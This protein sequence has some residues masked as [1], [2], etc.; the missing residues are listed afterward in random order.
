M[1]QHPK[2]MVLTVCVLFIIGAGYYLYQHGKILALSA[3]PSDNQYQLIVE[4]K[5]VNLEYNN[6]V[7]NS[8]NVA[9]S[10][11]ETLIKKGD[12]VEVDVAPYDRIVLTSSAEEFDSVP[13]RGKSKIEVMVKDLDFTKDNLQKID[14]VVRENRGRYA[15]STAKW[16]FYFTIERKVEFSDIV[17]NAFKSGSNKRVT[18]MQ[19]PTPLSSPPILVVSPKPSPTITSV[20][21]QTPIVSTSPTP[22]TKLV[23]ATPRNTTIDSINKTFTLGSSKEEVEAIMG[24]PDSNIFDSWSYKFSN[25]QF[26]NDKVIGWSNISRNLKVSIG[27]KKNDAK[28]VTIG[29]TKQQVVD[30]MGTPDSMMA[31]TWGY[32][33]STIEFDNEKVIG[34]SNISHNLIIFLGQKKQNAEPIKVDSTKQNVLDVMGTPD[35]INDYLWG[36]AFSTIQFRDGKVTGWSN[37]SNNL[38]I[39]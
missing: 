26:D 15:G 3:I 11:N 1:R 8:W 34:W 9:G 13:D 4:L 32:A 19:V 33:F 28:P 16:S 20:T 36:Y 24:A 35:S 38:K 7:G 29:S 30:A 12:T 14:V 10:V 25:L 6:H 22:K 17:A 31:N 18:T 2:G 5:S 39:K 27:N 37:I 23:T 21:T